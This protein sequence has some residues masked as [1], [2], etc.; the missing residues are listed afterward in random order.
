MSKTCP[1]IKKGK[2]GQSGFALIM[3]LGL[4]ALIVLL[5]LAL[6]AL[7]SIESTAARNVLMLRLAQQ[8]A[9]A[10]LYEAVGVLQQE[11]GRDN[12]VTARAEVL[13]TSVAHPL[14][15]GVWAAS[16]TQ[17]NPKWLVS[18]KRNASGDLIIKPTDS[19][20]GGTETVSIRA[21]ISSDPQYKSLHGNDSGEVVVER[22]R[23]ET[24]DQYNGGYA[25]WISDEGVKASVSLMSKALTGSLSDGNDLTQEDIRRA[26][27][28]TPLRAGLE[29]AFV[30]I[31]NGDDTSIELLGAEKL[32]QISHAADVRTLAY[33]DSDRFFSTNSDYIDWLSDDLTGTAYGV[34]A[35]TSVDDGTISLKT[36]LSTALVNTWSWILNGRN[37]NEISQLD[38][39]SIRMPAARSDWDAWAPALS[40]YL[41]IYKVATLCGGENTSGAQ[42][43]SFPLTAPIAYPPASSNQRP[44]PVDGTP[45]F[46]VA[47][48]LSE[49]ILAFGTYPYEKVGRVP[50]KW[51]SSSPGSAFTGGA[52]TAM[53]YG[54]DGALIKSSVACN[55][56][57]VMYCRTREH[58]HTEAAQNIKDGVPMVIRLFSSTEVWNPYTSDVQM[59]TEGKLQ[60][61]IKGLP[62]LRYSF[63]RRSIK[64]DTD[65]KSD[66]WRLIREAPLLS[67]QE[68]FESANESVSG[69][70]TLDLNRPA[71][72]VS[73][74]S[75]LLYAGETTPW[76]GLRSLNS[77]DQWFN[78]R[79]VSLYGLKDDRSIDRYSSGNVYTKGNNSNVEWAVPNFLS[80]TLAT[81]V[82][83][84]GVL[85]PV[86]YR[87]QDCNTISGNL[88]SAHTQYITSVNTRLN[89]RTESPADP[90]FEFELW[91]TRGNDAN[92]VF[93]SSYKATASQLNEGPE[94][95]RSSW[96]KRLC[97]EYSMMRA[98]WFFMRKDAYDAAQF[99]ENWLADENMASPND[100]R[101]DKSPNLFKEAAS[102]G[103]FYLE[104]NNVNP[105]RDLAKLQLLSKKN[106]RIS[107]LSG[108]F[109]MLTRAGSSAT[110]SSAYSRLFWVPERDFGASA[111][112]FELPTQRPVSLGNL[113]HLSLAGRRPFAIGNSWGHNLGENGKN[114]NAVFDKFY[115]SGLAPSATNSTDISSV[116]SNIDTDKPLL[117]AVLTPL[118][119]KGETPTFT[120]STDI[121]SN[122]LVKGAFNIN[123]TS[124]TAWKAML[125]GLWLND[126]EYADTSNFASNSFKRGSLGS[127]P[128]TL[129]ASAGVE[130]LTRAFFRY[131]YTASQTFVAPNYDAAAR[132]DDEDNA[133]FDYVKGVDVYPNHFR[134]GVRKLTQQQVS[135]MADSIVSQLRER[136]KPFTSMAEFL[137]PV[138]G[139]LSVLE[140]AIDEAGINND[141]GSILDGDFEGAEPLKGSSAY[142][143]Q[144]DL[145]NTLAPVLQAR[146][147]TFKIRAY[148]DVKNSTGQIEASAICEAIV[149]R[150]P[151]VAADDNASVQ[152]PGKWGRKF[153]I[154]SIRWIVE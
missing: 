114:A 23:I 102:P 136:G 35:D 105:T 109:G 149:Q 30:E 64:M 77:A 115:L 7:L 147:D 124:T 20:A 74:N 121:L 27:Q 88:Y 84:S 125:S 137:S 97:S 8:N 108:I 111:P 29:D 6:S 33:V 142:L 48:V 71:A 38:N 139:N 83:L 151:D 140:K 98:G 107:T 59:P 73:T 79:F 133:A 122:F 2:R 82:S 50:A 103:E 93:L 18:G 118:W 119:K 1:L 138:S 51:P 44:D 81:T 135:D 148:G 92:A 60:L 42:I 78:G 46:S 4:M 16:G 152:I 52:C 36:D 26:R 10:A 22:M 143:T 123:S 100:I 53:K 41:N 45:V 154:V 117:N 58:V 91:Y 63:Y 130:P 32:E 134:R 21:A 55:A 3:A 76:A 39:P 12:A 40:A 65:W 95:N 89:L 69:W 70:A 86:V 68:I 80:Q 19:F 129:T 141:T 146:S 37:N 132:A 54:P 13:G 127:K 150:Y 56:S 145:L 110:L 72:N 5:L 126:W 28:Y 104:G 106:G 62:N 67:L 112:V 131:P 66:S 144:A 85:C 49:F 113:Q 94:D 47:P 24:A 15:T 128:K 17:T 153:R 34:L 90:S 61:R 87:D 75:F 11:A 14:W 43:Y 96:W 31:K 120:D 116:L 57:G 9:R 101:Q 99:G 25:W